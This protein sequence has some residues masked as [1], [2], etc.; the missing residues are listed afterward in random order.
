MKH[1]EGQPCYIFIT[2]SLLFIGS[3]RNWG[4]GNKILFAIFKFIEQN[5]R[6]AQAQKPLHEQKKDNIVH[7]FE[8]LKKNFQYFTKYNL[9]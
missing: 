4:E 3:Q 9:Y 5:F 8:Y 1:I 2:V 6:H 7:D